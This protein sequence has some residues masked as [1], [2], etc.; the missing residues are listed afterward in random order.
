[1]LALGGDFSHSMTISQLLK[2]IAQKRHLDPL[3][4][5]LAL[6]PDSPHGLGVPCQP[7]STVGSL[8]GAEV[9]VVRNSSQ[10]AE[11]AAGRS[12]SLRG[13]GE[14]KKVPRPADEEGAMSRADGGSE[15]VGTLFFIRSVGKG[16]LSLIITSPS[17]SLFTFPHHLP[18]H[19]YI[20]LLPLRAAAL[21]FLRIVRLHT[22]T[23]LLRPLCSKLNCQ[24][25]T[26]WRS[27]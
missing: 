26:R 18:H 11:G 20:M 14:G 16:S 3:Q 10:P 23:H 12:S 2:L 19:P 21:A 8:K 4:Y 9:H 22:H 1:M 15:Q 7:Q 25:A 17:T 13:G 6:P 24:R 5:T 27:E